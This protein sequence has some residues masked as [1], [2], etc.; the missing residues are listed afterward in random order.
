VGS[1]QLRLTLRDDGRGLAL[2]K[3]RST[4][5]EKGL[6]RAD[7]R[8][9]PEA[10]AQLIFM[11]GFSTADKVTEVSGRGVG[12]D[13]VKGF[14]HKEGGDIEIRFLDEREGADFRPFELLITLPEKY[15]VQPGRWTRLHDMPQF[16]HTM[17][18]L[19]LAH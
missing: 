15:A 16:V 1:G 3:I 13:A 4:A 14:L 10:I 7:E 11:S 5:I 18:G 2:A 17:P 12:M 19:G 8:R 9:S 6:L